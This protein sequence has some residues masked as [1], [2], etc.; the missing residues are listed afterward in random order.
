L[1]FA[2]SL[3]AKWVSRWTIQCTSSPFISYWK[4]EYFQENFVLF[5]MHS[6][7]IGSRFRALIFPLCLGIQWAPAASASN[8]LVAHRT[9]HQVCDMRLPPWDF[10]DSS[11]DINLKGVGPFRSSC[12]L[13]F[14][15]GMHEPLC[16]FPCV[17]PPPWMYIRYFFLRLAS[18]LFAI[19]RR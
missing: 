4:R 5:R 11:V 12:I 6:R 3:N 1:Y 16:I 9:L 17:V 13:P 7:T 18:Q 19:F 15:R 8:K 14:W 10:I 2:L